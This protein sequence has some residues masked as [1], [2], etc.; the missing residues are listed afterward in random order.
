MITASIDV[1]YILLNEL[2]AFVIG[3]LKLSNV[4]NSEK[5]FFADLIYLA[6]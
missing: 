2:L 3:I 6:I 5:E 4:P 1:A